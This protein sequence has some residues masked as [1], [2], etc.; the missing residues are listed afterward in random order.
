[1]APPPLIAAD[2]KQLT[3]VTDETLARLQAYADVLEKWQKKINLVGSKTLPDLWRRHMLDSAQLF[4]HLPEGPDEMVIVDMGSGAGFP[5]L[6]LAAMSGVD[7]SIHLIE[8]D[9]R[10]C[11]FLAEAARVMDVTPKTHIHADRIEAVEGLVADVVTAR[12]LTALGDLLGYA[13]P[14]LKPSTT[15]LFPKGKT[16]DDELTLAANNWKMSTTEIPS[17]SDPSGTILKLEAVSAR[18]D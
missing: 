9:A 12:A 3:G 4:A 10:K 6:V 1:M 14:F 5:G 15:C 7:V 17:L 11:A 13:Q 2:F 8:S 16:A 18:D